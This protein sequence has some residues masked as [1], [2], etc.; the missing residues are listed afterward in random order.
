MR[1]YVASSWRNE[2]QPEVVQFLRDNRYQVYDF[3]NPLAGDH[4]FHW[5]DI[6][7][8]WQ[9]WTPEQYRAALEHKLARDVFATDMKALRTCDAVVAVQPFGRSTSLELG[10]ACGAGKR[11][12]LLLAEGEPELMVKMVDH[13]CLNLPEVLIALEGR[14]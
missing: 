2:R 7:A 10:W 9:Q 8:D 12:V 14:A 13:L 5:S 11:T 4:S 6:S 3:R 1:V